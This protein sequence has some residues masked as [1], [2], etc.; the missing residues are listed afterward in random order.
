MNIVM[1]HAPGAGHI[2]MIR[3]LDGSYAYYMLSTSIGQMH[4]YIAG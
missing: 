4:Q 1:N 3:V 2:A